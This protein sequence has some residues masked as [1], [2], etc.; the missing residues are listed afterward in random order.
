MKRTAQNL[1]L[2]DFEDSSR[3]QFNDVLFSF[4]IVTNCLLL[5]QHLFLVHVTID[6]TGQL[7]Q[8][9][10]TCLAILVPRLMEEPLPGKYVHDRRK[11]T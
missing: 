2:L 6:S 11:S 3:F 4:A 1:K 5:Q 8:L 9:C 7:L 10:S